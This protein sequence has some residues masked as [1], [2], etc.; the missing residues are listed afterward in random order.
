[1]TAR[2]E[3][4][5]RERS[6]PPDP[7]LLVVRERLDAVARLVAAAEVEQEH[8]V[9]GLPQPRSEAQHVASRRG[10]RGR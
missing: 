4:A 5:A 9:A 2:R 10:G 7:L 6:R 8:G 3:L 1:M